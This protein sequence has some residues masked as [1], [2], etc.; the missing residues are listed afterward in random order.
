[1]LD[2]RR[3]D[4]SLAGRLAVSRQAQDGQVVALGG[5]AGEDHLVW[6]G[7]DDRCDLLACAVDS[8]LGDLAV[9]WV[10]LPALPNS[11]DM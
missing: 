11:W 4:V 1:M 7:A 9:P 2:L 6:L 10:R 3:D 5:A 8:L